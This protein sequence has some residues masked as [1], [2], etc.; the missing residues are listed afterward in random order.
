VIGRFEA[1]SDTD[2]PQS[3]DVNPHATWTEA[4]RRSVETEPVVL[5]GLSDERAYE[6]LVGRD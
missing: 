5:A 3:G 4:D 6:R 2:H 1:S